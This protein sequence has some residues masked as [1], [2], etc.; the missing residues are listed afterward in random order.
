[1]CAAQRS[2]VRWNTPWLA[3][4]A[5]QPDEHAA[6]TF[7]AT[8]VRRPLPVTPARRR[9]TRPH[10]RPVP[11]RRVTHRPPTAA[12]PVTGALPGAPRRS[13]DAAAL[14]HD[15]G[16]PTRSLTEVEGELGPPIGPLNADA[17]VE[18]CLVEQT[19]ST[20]DAIGIRRAVPQHQGKSRA[21]GGWQCCAAWAPPRF[22]ANCP[23]SRQPARRRFSDGFQSI[24]QP[25]L[26]LA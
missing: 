7:L 15:R 11:R 9:P 6:H 3:G 5:F 17:A 12:P 26:F 18:E 25:F 13:R 19:A 8:D 14:P 20:E 1:M 24:I 21:A 22:S 10:A 2:G 16:W 4:P 23:A